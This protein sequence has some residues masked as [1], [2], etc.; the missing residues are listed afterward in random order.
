M[1]ELWVLVCL[2]NNI[3]TSVGTSKKYFKQQLDVTTVNLTFLN[4]FL[5]QLCQPEYFVEAEFTSKGSS[6]YQ[7]YS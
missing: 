4:L 2:L 5:V 3:N 1:R 6:Y 7:I